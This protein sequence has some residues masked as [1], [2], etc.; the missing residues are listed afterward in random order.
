MLRGSG[1]GFYVD[2]GKVVGT[3]DGMMTRHV[4]REYPVGDLIGPAMRGDDLMQRVL[5]TVEPQSWEQRGGQG[6]LRYWDTSKDL[7]AATTRATQ[8]RLRVYLE[9]LRQGLDGRADE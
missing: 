7:V 3:S 9:R 2:D 6:T 5:Q 4:M 1:L 8:E